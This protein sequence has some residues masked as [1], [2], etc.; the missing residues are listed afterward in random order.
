MMYYR[1]LMDM[2]LCVQN[3]RTD[4]R[5]WFQIRWEKT[6]PTLLLS[7]NVALNSERN[8]GSSYMKPLKSKQ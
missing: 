5:I 2:Y 8:T 3:V 1:L 7:L 6:H 4:L